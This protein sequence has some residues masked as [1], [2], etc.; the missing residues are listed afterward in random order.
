MKFISVI[1]ARKGSKGIINK[2]TLK[3][4]GRPLVE[5][6]FRS[7]KSSLLKQNFV[8]TDCKKIKNI[9]RRFNINS[10]YVRP[11]NLSGS[12]I[13]L[14]ENLFYFFNYLEKKIK[15]DYMVVLQP[16]S[17]LRNYKDINKSIKF[18]KKRKSL[19]LFSISSSLEHPYEAIK[20]SKKKKWSFILKKSKK[21]YR[22][23]DFDINSFFINGA[24][25]IIHRKLIKQKKMY[26]L[27]RHSFYEMPKN[28]SIE[29][30]DMSEAKIV[31][32]I[33]KHERI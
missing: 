15:F 9:A 33:V 1:L 17:P 27:T 11:R 31:E 6:T 22:R 2:N 28:R 29:I 18:I 4:N 20:I 30:N 8:L 3:I 16:T 24:V 26:S 7:A 23:Q 5:Y 19:S 25:Y 21:F 12:K 32:S 14:I 10:D 13:S